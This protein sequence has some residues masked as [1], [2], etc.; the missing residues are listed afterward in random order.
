MTTF[1]L[2]VVA[3]NKDGDLG[4]CYYN[5]AEMATHMTG[6]SNRYQQIDVKADKAVMVAA[7]KDDKL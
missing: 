3:T 5:L 7:D 6:C 1:K 4:S 2:V